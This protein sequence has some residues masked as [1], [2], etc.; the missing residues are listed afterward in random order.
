LQDIVYFNVRGNIDQYALPK[1]LMQEFKRMSGTM[2]RLSGKD[3]N[4][5]RRL[6]GIYHENSARVHRKQD[7]Q[8]ERK[9]GDREAYIPSRQQISI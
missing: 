9:Q 5:V 6:G 8:Y 3:E 7:E 1:T 4:Q 2:I